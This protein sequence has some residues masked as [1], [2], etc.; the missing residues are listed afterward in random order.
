MVFNF[1]KNNIIDILQ[2]GITQEILDNTVSGNG[3]KLFIFLIISRFKSHHLNSNRSQA[4]KRK[5]V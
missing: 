3:L 1:N 5:C 4:A 2:K